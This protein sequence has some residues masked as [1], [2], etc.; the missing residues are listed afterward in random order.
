MTI[1]AV[2]SLIHWV[3]L[4]I[5]VVYAWTRPMRPN[6]PKTKATELA[7]EIRPI[8]WICAL[9][10]AIHGG[11]IWLVQEYMKNEQSGASNFIGLFIL[12]CWG[13]M[14]RQWYRDWKNSDDDRWKKRRNKLKAKVKEVAGK[15]V[16]EPEPEL[17]R[18]TA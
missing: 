5:G 12:V 7:A 11:P 2:L 13:F 9:Y 15:L 1:F 17:V 10:V 6:S 3:A 14:S 8:A 4:V 16:V 18:V